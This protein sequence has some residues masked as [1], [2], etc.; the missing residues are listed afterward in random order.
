MRTPQAGSIAVSSPRTGD[1]AELEGADAIVGD[2][3]GIV[4]ALLDAAR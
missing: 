3:E 1:R 2:M 4:A